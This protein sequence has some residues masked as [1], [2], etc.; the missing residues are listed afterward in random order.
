[1]PFG[2]DIVPSVSEPNILLHDGQLLTLDGTA[3]SPAWGIGRW[4]LTDP[5]DT[6]GFS[7]DGSEVRYVKVVPPGRDWA[8]YVWRNGHLPGLLQHPP[9]TDTL[10]FTVEAGGDG[11]RLRA[12]PTMDAQILVTLP[13]GT[14]GVVTSDAPEQYG[15]ETSAVPDAGLDPPFEERQWWIHIRTEAG[16]EGWVAAEFLDWAP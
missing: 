9:F 8:V 2:G 4:Q 7:A 13:D 11:L 15:F 5:N 14:R 1:L 10:P 6:M 16:Q 3:L 12:S